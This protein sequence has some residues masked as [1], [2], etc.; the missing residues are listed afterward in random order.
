VAT[1][2][3]KALGTSASGVK[4]GSEGGVAVSAE[5]TDGVTVVGLANLVTVQGSPPETCSV[6]ALP[7]WGDGVFGVKGL[8]AG[9]CTVTAT[10]GDKTAELTV[11]IQ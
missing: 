10:L 4:V 11:E 3:I 1:L 6:R 5:T 8:A 9:T 2:D 7:M